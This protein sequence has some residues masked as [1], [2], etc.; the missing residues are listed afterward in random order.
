MGGNFDNILSK[1]DIRKSYGNNYSAICPAHQDRNPSLSITDCGDKLLIHCF[2]GCST[3]DVLDAVG[4]H[5]NQ[6]FTIKTDFIHSNKKYT[7]T[8]DY[9][10]EEGNFLYTLEK[11]KGADARKTFRFYHYK[12]QRKVYNLS[13]VRIVLYR[14]PELI[15][16]LKTTSQVFICEGE[17]DADTL[18]NLGLLATTN[19]MGAEAW[20]PDFNQYFHDKNVII[21]QDND[22][23]GEKRTKKLIAELQNI[24]KSIKVIVFNDLPKGSD[25]TDWILSHGGNKQKLLDL[26]DKTPQTNTKFET[27]DDIQLF[28]YADKKTLINHRLVKLL[29]DKFNIRFLHDKNK[30]LLFNG[31]DWEEVPDSHIVCLFQTWLKETHRK[32]RYFKSILEDLKLNKSITISSKEINNHLHCLN[33]NNTI[34]QTIEIKAIQHSPLYYFDYCLDYDYDPRADCPTFKKILKDYSL[35]DDDW[36]ALIQEIGGYLL[37]DGLPFQ[38]MFWFFSNSGRNGKGTIL[39]VFHS[40]LGNKY[41]KPDFDTKQLKDSRFYKLDLKNKRLIYSGDMENQIYALNAIK[42]LTGGD[43][44]TSDV[45]FGNSDMFYVQGKFIF[46]MNNLPKI[47]GDENKE[48]LRKRIIFLPFFYRIEQPNSTIEQELIKERSGIL[49]FFLEGLKRLI[50]QQKFTETKLGNFILSVFM[51]DNNI[52][53]IF[54]DNFVIHDENAEGLYLEDI[55]EVY[56]TLVEM[57]SNPKTINK[58][59]SML[60][61]NNRNLVNLL[62]LKYPTITTNIRSLTIKEKKGTYTFIEKIKFEEKLLAIFAKKRLSS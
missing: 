56:Q 31:K 43:M 12:E 11:T 42:S 14:L 47:N 10:D 49:N 15:E 51:E 55:K 18:M 28:I 52:L 50:N 3:D 21:M 60:K 41:V 38:K 53:E 40:I 26:V 24:A 6:L 62:K 34:I 61:I 29:I 59:Y 45:K 4:L 22:E 39:R 44:Q 1:F 54:L 32:S 9:Q 17:K 35:D 23:A 46:S 36:I 48:P 5:F 33:L 27:I 58:H 19:P 37:M 16:G 13:G 20:K 8:Y 7:I 25:V 57:I 30:F 2:A